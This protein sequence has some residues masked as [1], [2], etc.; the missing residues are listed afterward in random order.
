[1]GCRSIFHGRRFTQN[2]SISSATSLRWREIHEKHSKVTYACSVVSFHWNKGPQQIN[3]VHWIWYVDVALEVAMNLVR[4]VVLLQLSTLSQEHY[5]L[6]GH[7]SS[8]FFDSDIGLQRPCKG[9]Y[10]ASKYEAVI[11]LDGFLRP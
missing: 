1:M 11:R 7:V 10:L 9:I 3:S 2:I 5:L 6:S 8:L 4:R